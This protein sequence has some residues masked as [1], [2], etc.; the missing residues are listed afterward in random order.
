VIPLRDTNPNERT[1]VVVLA[2]IAANALVFW[3]ELSVPAA[4]QESMFYIFGV[5]PAR[6]IDPSDPGFS[7]FPGGYMPF[8]TSMFL[9]GGWMHLLGNMWFLW[10]FGDNVEDRMGRGRFLWFYLLC[11]L[12]AGATHLALNPHSPVPTIG[13]SGAI[14]GVMGAY[15]FTFPRARVLTLVPLGF[16]IRLMELPAWVFL[17]VW[18]VFQFFNGALT[19]AATHGQAAGVAFWAHVGGFVAGIALRP[20]FM[21]GSARARTWN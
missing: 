4:R 5:V 2:L 13:A 11:G 8:V 12:A 16:F 15:A 7:H 19:T 10:L 20:A 18:F 14:A 3:W 21:R 1:P 17:G 6:Y 9:H